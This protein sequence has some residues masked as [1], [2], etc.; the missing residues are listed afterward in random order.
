ME[1]HLLGVEARRRRGKARAR[2]EFGVKTSI[3]VTNARQPG[4]QFVLGAWTLPGNPY[5]GRSLAV[6]I[7]Q[8]ARLTERT[9]QRA[10]VDRG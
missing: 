4:G 6:Q 8:V 2:Y 7:D 1:A 3:T 5:D 9:A 10:Y